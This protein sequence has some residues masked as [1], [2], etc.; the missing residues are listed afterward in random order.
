LLPGTRAPATTDSIVD[1]L[2]QIAT[3]NGASFN[4]DS[5]GTLTLD[6]TRA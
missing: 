2:N 5:K 1:V 3:Q 6:M 4:H